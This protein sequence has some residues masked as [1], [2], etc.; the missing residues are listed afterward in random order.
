MTG[1]LAS[2]STP[3]EVDIVC[4]EGVDMVDLKQPSEGALGALSRQNVAAIVRRVAGRRPVSATIGDLPMQADI[5]YNAVRQMADTG[6]DIV[7][8]GMFPDADIRPIIS[9]LRHATARGINIVAVL[10]ADVPLDIKTT[11]LLADAGFRGAMLDTM[12]KSGRSL[13]DCLSMSTVEEFVHECRQNRLLCGLAGSLRL[14]DIPKLLPLTPDYLGFR[15]ALCVRGVRQ[16]RLARAA[17]K[18]VRRAI[19]SGNELNSIPTQSAS[20]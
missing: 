4:A 6:V 17:V 8:V 3:D 11:T 2:V 7:K 1:F 20:G 14:S 12:Q 15:G 16:N 19:G 9:S 18:T 10:F 5:V 13:L